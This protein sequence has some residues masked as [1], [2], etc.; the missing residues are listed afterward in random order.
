MVSFQTCQSPSPLLSSFLSFKPMLSPIPL[1]LHHTF[2]FPKQP[3]HHSFFLK[4]MV[5]YVQMQRVMY[6]SQLLVVINMLHLMQQQVDYLRDDHLLEEAT[7]SWP[8]S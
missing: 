5:F 3:L 6:G 7:D 4:K 8:G 2:S 1:T